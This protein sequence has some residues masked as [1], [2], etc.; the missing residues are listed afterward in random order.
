MLSSLNFRIFLFFYYATVYGKMS[1]H[2]EKKVKSN[3]HWSVTITSETA[4]LDQSECRKINSHLEIYTNIYE[5]PHAPVIFPI[6]L[7]IFNCFENSDR[8]ENFRQTVL[9][10]GRGGGGSGW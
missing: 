3:S 6:S 8:A 7:R 4:N 2:F 9:I 10:N 1:R 5:L